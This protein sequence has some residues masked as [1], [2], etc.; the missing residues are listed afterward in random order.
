MNK[1]SGV[2]TLNYLMALFLRV[3]EDFDEEKRHPRFSRMIFS[4]KPIKYDSQAYIIMS[5]NLMMNSSTI[6]INSFGDEEL[7]K[8]EMRIIQQFLIIF[9]IDIQLLLV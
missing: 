4:R 9:W 6:K 5:S 7:K 2:K 3:S 8:I 1:P